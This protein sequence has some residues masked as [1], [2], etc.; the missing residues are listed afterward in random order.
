MSSLAGCNNM[1][2]QIDRDRE[3]E[4]EKESETEPA[5]HL[6]CRVEI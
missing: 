4:T 1:M 5:H 2:R 3:T 6:R